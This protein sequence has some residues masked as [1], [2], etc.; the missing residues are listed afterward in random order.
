MQSTCSFDGCE[1]R[2]YAKGLCNGHYIQ[3]RKGQELRPLRPR[4]LEGRFWTKVN[5]SAPGG[6]WEWV[7]AITHTGY[8]HFGANGSVHRAHR[9]SWELVNGAIPEGMDLDHRCANRKCVNPGHLRVVTR[10][11]N[12]QHLT[13][14][15]SNNASGVRGVYWHQQYN[16]WVVE[17]TLA[18]V[19]Y[20]GGRHSTI[21]AAAAAARA[22]R[23]ELFTH[24]DHDEWIKNSKKE[25]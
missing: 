21:E 4:T 19:R 25:K 17:V 22:L 5:K 7:A 11:E 9:V 13:S 2:H 14:A 12:N 10:S 1:N 20:S 6:C 8:G 24:D 16:A 15:Y 18:G 3:H 23:K